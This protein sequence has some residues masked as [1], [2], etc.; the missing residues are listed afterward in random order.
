[1]YWAAHIINAELLLH[2]HGYIFSEEIKPKK[3]EIYFFVMMPCNTDHQMITKFE[4]PYREGAYVRSFSI[5]IATIVHFFDI[6]VS[7]V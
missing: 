1:M 4:R 5:R 6:E 7:T 2:D 3:R